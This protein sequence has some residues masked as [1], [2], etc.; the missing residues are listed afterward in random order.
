MS[1]AIFVSVLGAALLHAV[2]NAM[3]KGGTDKL[4]SMTAVTV[5]QG[6]FGVAVLPFATLP[7]AA[8]WPFLLASVGLHVGYQVFLLQAY[9]VGDLTQVYPIARGIAPLIVAAVSV[10]VLGVTLQPLELLGVLVIASGIFSLG[11]VRRADGL[12]NRKAA[13]FAAITGAFIAGYS[14][15]DGTG[16]R[17]AGTALGFYGVSALGNALA[18]SALVTA[19]RPAILRQTARAWRV[20]LIGGGASYVAYAIVVHAFTLAPIALVSALRETSIVFALVIGVTTLGE[21]LDLGKVVSTMI[22]FGGA[23]LLRLGRG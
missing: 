3:V 21:R 17:I 15:N 23:A 10:L 1:T 19:R 18:F 11:L 8:S 12:K 13:V 22:T 4:V 20:V 2:W 14:L 16:A 6:L 5:G 9:R 7:G